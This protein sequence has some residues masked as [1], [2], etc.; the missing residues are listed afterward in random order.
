MTT[1][2]NTISTTVSLP[3]NIQIMGFPSLVLT[4]IFKL[5]TLHTFNPSKCLQRILCI[6]GDEV[7]KRLL[8][9]LGVNMFLAVCMEL[10]FVALFPLGYVVVTTSEVCCDCQG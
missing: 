8:I 10:E 3:D 1:A 2:R 6:K 9:Y 5:S 7:V 4:I